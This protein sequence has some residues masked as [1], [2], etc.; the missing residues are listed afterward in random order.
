MAVQY[1]N[2]QLYDVWQPGM[3]SLINPSIFQ[4]SGYKMVNYGLLN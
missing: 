2:G 4:G 1:I 3:S